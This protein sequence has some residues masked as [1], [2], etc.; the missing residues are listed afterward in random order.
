MVDTE[1]CGAGACPHRPQEE[2]GQWAVSLQAWLQDSA[3]QN[4]PREDEAQT[5]QRGELEAPCPQLGLAWGITEDGH[6]RLPTHR[7]LFTLLLFFQ[8]GLLPGRERRMELVL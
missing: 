7:L 3:Q 5:R 1:L 2:A 4:L 6:V 8:P